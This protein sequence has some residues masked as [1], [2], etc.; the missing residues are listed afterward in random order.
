MSQFEFQHEQSQ[1]AEQAEEADTI[2]IPAGHAMTWEDLRHEKAGE[3][4]Q[5][6]AM[7]WEDAHRGRA[8][9]EIP[10]GPVT[11]WEDL[12]HEHAAP[13][14]PIEML[15]E[16]EPDRQS[17]ELADS[18][19]GDI[20]SRV[21]TLSRDQA[22]IRALHEEL[23]EEHFREYS[24]GAPL[25]DVAEGCQRMAEEFASARRM[26][27][28]IV[29]V[30]TGTLPIPISVSQ[31]G[32]G[33]AQFLRTL[34]KRNASLA[35][36]M[37]MST[38]DDAISQD[39]NLRKQTVEEAEETASFNLRTFL[40]FR[41]WGWKNRSEGVSDGYV[42]IG[43]R[44]ADAATGGGL[45]VRVFTRNPGLRIKAAPAYFIDD[46]L[47][48]G[49]PTSPAEGYLLPGRYIFFADGLMYTR[50]KMD[51]TIFAIPP[52]LKVK[53]TRF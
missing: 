5:G 20:M 32:L 16:G 15:P 29:C 21:K 47:F 53:L 46:L 1:E 34:T 25:D 14:E 18:V 31:L 26:E 4:P 8:A 17:F 35:R 37:V 3:I 6:R 7:H 51:P 48:F 30:E 44:Y 11:E 22:S 49:H 40:S 42:N 41:Y 36:D 13:P 33:S 28:P 24:S 12:R 45:K 43:Q 27:R 38:I 52:S 50:P 10:A 19:T 39:P 9:D 23:G 2:E